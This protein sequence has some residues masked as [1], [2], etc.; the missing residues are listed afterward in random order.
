MARRLRRSD[1]ASRAKL[2][3]R[4]DEFLLPPIAMQ[5]QAADPRRQ[6]SR[7][8]RTPRT[9]TNISSRTWKAVDRRIEHQPT[10]GPQS[11][12]KHRS[13]R[14]KPRLLST[15][16]PHAG[17]RSWTVQRL[18]PSW[19]CEFDSRHPLQQSNPS[20]RAFLAWGHEGRRRPTGWAGVLA[21][22]Q[23][24]SRGNQQPD[25]R[26]GSHPCLACAPGG[27]RHRGALSASSCLRPSAL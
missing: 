11:G 15:L 16:L 13:L 6:E 25:Q 26:N 4:H 17:G 10:T 21:E 2:Q 24:L 22:R 18:L 1:C 14:G 7:C 27:Q 9:V 12:H 5:R 3:G 19:S 23:E 20:Q 8:S